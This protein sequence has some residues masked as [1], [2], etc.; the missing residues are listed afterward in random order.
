MSNLDPRAPGKTP[1]ALS[2]GKHGAPTK[3]AATPRKGRLSPDHV[4][5]QGSKKVTPQRG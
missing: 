3:S 4:Q 5:G 1:E 2:A